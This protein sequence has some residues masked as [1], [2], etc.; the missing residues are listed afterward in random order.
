MKA[1]TPLLLIVDDDSAIRF[2]LRDLLARTGYQVA[3]AG[4]AAQAV[5]ELTHRA[6]DLL[7]LDL[8]LGADNGLHVLE[9]FR[10]RQPEGE[11]LILTAH[12]SLDS[13]LA[14]MQLGVGDYLLKPVSPNLLLK[15]IDQALARHHR[16]LARQAALSAILTGAQQLLGEE[17]TLPDESL[18]LSLAAGEPAVLARG[19]VRVDLRACQPECQGVAFTLSPAQF[20]LLVIL[21]QHSDR[22]LSCQQLARMLYGYDVD[23]VEARDLIRPLIKRLRDV[24]ARQGA[25]HVSII[26][27][28]GLGYMLQTTGTDTLL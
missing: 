24:L 7:I 15:K 21:M 16:T 17:L 1:R 27:M 5:S 14:A 2:V 9:F 18:G 3:V 8:K 10:E 19:D 25:R 22:V 13:A 28:R 26:N 11:A 20:R 4:D 6:F 12:G 23:T